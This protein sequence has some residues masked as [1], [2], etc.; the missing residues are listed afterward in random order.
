MQQKILSNFDYQH[1]REFIVQF[2]DMY[3]RY[4]ITDPY[5]KKWFLPRYDF[6]QIH[7]PLMVKFLC[8]ILN[9][10]DVFLDLG[11]HIGYFSIIGALLCNHVYTFEIDDNCVPIIK[12]NIAHNQLTNITLLNKAIS[13]R[14]H[15]TLKISSFDSPNPTLSI[16][17]NS[18][19]DNYK[20]VETISVDDF[21]IS[22]SIQPKVIKIDIEGA[23]FHA[24]QG[25]VNTM[26][27][28][29]NLHVLMEVHPKQLRAS[30][31]SQKDIIELIYDTG[32]TAK[33]FGSHRKHD[34]HSAELVKP[35]STFDKNTML[36]I[37]R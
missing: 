4:D 15:E 1:K 27:S 8:R 9:K 18:A 22:N 13:N 7:E 6:G 37:K 33:H 5:S 26:K 34:N 30:G 2:L 35:N 3:A 12:K 25:M 16:R 11:G 21:C 29:T 24:L 31:V 28:A 10:N 19:R 32:Y 14:S 20:C 17:Y 23:E 36:H